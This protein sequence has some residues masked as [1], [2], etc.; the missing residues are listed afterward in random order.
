M[1]ERLYGGV[2]LGVPMGTGLCSPGRCE[3]GQLWWGAAYPV[4]LILAAVL[5]ARG[6]RAAAATAEAPSVTGAATATGT[7][8]GRVE[9]VRFALVVAAAL[10]LLSYATSAAAGQ[11]P[12]E[13]ARYLSCLLIST[14][15]V[16]WPVWRALT[17][18]VAA[19][20][21]PPILRWAVSFLVIALL[22]GSAVFATGSLL[23]DAPRIARG[24]ANQAEL[25]RVLRERGAT[26][27]YSD[28]WTCDRTIFATR[29][30][31]ACAVLDDDLRP[32][33]D[34]YRP[35]RTL[36]GRARRPSY[37]LLADSPLDRHFRALLDHQ[38]MHVT[39][40][41]AGGYR[42]YDPPQ[43]VLTPQT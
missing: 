29:E 12:V 42:I 9:L 38:R 33:L 11:T 5:A 17:N 34:R 14:P 16:L 8:A 10:S 31:V 4:L 30:Q 40:V 35:Y 23:A 13:S 43:P 7:A 28:Y 36:V 22:A 32:G 19:R 6:L 1:G 25:T 24:R 27:I 18:R 2:L 26:R 37:V 39:P 41:E 3:P 15:A 20:P 21:R